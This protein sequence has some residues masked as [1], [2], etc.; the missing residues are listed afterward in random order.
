MAEWF[1]LLVACMATQTLRPSL[2]CSVGMCAP[3]H[4]D[5]VGS[6]G[7][8]LVL[9]A[10]RVFIE[11]SGSVQARIKPSTPTQ[12]PTQVVHCRSVQV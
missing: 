2:H 7:C 11:S 10:P 5:S 4:I 6:T 1:A 9:P 3:L 12:S 8:A